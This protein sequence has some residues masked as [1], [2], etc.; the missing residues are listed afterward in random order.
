[1]QRWACLFIFRP[2][3]EERREELR[4]VIEESDVIW[5]FAQYRDVTEA[6]KPL[7][8]ALKGKTLVLF[9]EMVVLS[10]VPERLAEL[11]LFIDEV[12]SAAERIVI[13]YLRHRIVWDADL[14]RRHA[15]I[16]AGGV[17]PYIFVMDFATQRQLRFIHYQ[18]FNKYLK[19]SDV[20]DKLR[21]LPHIVV[22]DGE[23][24]IRVP[25]IEVLRLQAASE[26]LV[27]PTRV[28]GYSRFLLHGILLGCV[29]ILLLTDAEML[30][31]YTNAAST[32]KFA[33]FRELSRY[34][35][36]C[37]DEASF[38]ATVEHLFAH[39]QEIPEHRQRVY[40]FLLHHRD[41]WCPEIIHDAFA[42]HDLFLPADLTP[43]SHSFEADM[44]LFPVG[45][46]SQNL[47]SKRFVC[48]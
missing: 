43:V 5:M 41:L 22:G 15:V 45:K 37:P 4:T 42:E 30:F 36:V 31:V 14:E 35:L 6:L 24:A 16:R 17:V 28:D 10:L 26:L 19:G 12:G 1:M 32:D 23:G 9:R 8:D 27:H 3:P 2:V 34:F 38:L 48:V 20:V 44:R 13:H 25:F 7:K 33:A 39:P 40:E 18:A 29:P 11:R 21:H 46:W 47:P